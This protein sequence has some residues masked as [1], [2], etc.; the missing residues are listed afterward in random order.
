[1]PIYISMLRGIN[2]GGNKKIKM[3]D[4]R[5]LYTTLGMA[6]VQSVLQS[7]NVAFKHDS[8]DQA[9]LTRQLEAGIEQQFGFHSDILLLTLAEFADIIRQ[10]P[11]ATEDA[12]PSKLVIMFL[13]HTPGEEEIVALSAAHTGPE[14]VEFGEKAA[15]LYYPNGMGR[16]KL[17]NVFIEVKLKV[18]GTARNWNTVNKLLCLAQT[19]DD[20]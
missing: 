10:H 15:Y 7:G 9:K 6:D 3:A 1:M 19:L 12:D 14:T 13:S 16:S 18:T 5:E 4:L 11:R 17:T 2:V 8:T 20:D